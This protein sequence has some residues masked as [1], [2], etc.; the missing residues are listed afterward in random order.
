MDKQITEAEALAAMK[1]SYGWK[2]VE[3]WVKSAQDLSMTNILNPKK[4][5]NWN[6]FVHYRATNNAY[7]KLLAVIDSKIERGVRAK[8]KNESWQ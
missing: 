2:I 1:E 5:K 8:E 7:A 6:D 4:N 3:Q